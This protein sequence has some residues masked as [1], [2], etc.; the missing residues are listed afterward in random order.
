MKSN[1]YKAMICSVLA[2]GLMLSPL[3]GQSAQTVSAA[4]AA[5][6]KTEH[7]QLWVDGAQIKLSGPIAKENGIALVPMSDLLDPLDVTYVLEKKTNTI[8]IR[9]GGTTLTMAIGKK[10]AIVN[11]A[12]RKM[13]AAAV[14]KNNIPY[15]P[16]RFVAEE[17]EA[18]VEWDAETSKIHV[19]SWYY[20]EY[21]QYEEEQ[22]YEAPG[23]KLTATDIV[24]LY[25]GSVVMIM[26][27][28]ALGSG[29][30]IGEDLV[31]T[32]FHVIEDATSATVQSIYYDEIEVEGVVAVNEI[33]DLAIIRTSEPM[34]LEPVELS[35]GYQARK[36]DRVYAIGSPLGVQNTVST[37]LISNTGYDGGISYIQTNAQTDHGSSGG[38][39][40]NEYGELIGI[41]YAG[42]DGS[43]ADLNFAIQAFQAAMLFDSVT[44]EMVEEAEFLTPSLPE[45]LAG[46]P[47]EDI[48]D[49]MEEEFGLVQTLQGMVE[50]TDWEA[51]R[52]AEGWLVLTAN[53]DPLYY[54]YYGEAT[55]G[56]LRLWAVNLATELHRM[57]PDEQIQ[58]Q[59]SF[60]RDYSFR[61]RNLAP[62]EVTSIGNGKWRVRYPVI[63]MQLNDQLYI[64][65]RF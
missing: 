53:I 42:I 39:L 60:E 22:P 46:A 64:E 37:G 21:E 55:A 65:T 32:N 57:L 25:D 15:I 19:K 51:K 63:D 24:D 49:L 11:G 40:F 59:I 35:Y 48:R 41:T 61:P 45:T 56:E 52:D 7:I 33:A 8:I 29:I 47:L 44:D 50:F 34:D 23:E 10:E 58:V 2:A 5:A 36:G 1:W 18:D 54:M 4:S 14:I 28:R 9:D 30:V 17:L 20:Q 13:D 62:D 38:A 3:S 26:T 12:T 6:V 31:L 43:Y 27:N 16:L